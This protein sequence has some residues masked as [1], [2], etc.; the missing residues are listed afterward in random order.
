L[1]DSWDEYLGTSAA[2]KATEIRAAVQAHSILE[3]DD[4]WRRTLSE[5]ADIQCGRQL[6]HLFAVVL[7]FGM[8]DEPENVKTKLSTTFVVARHRLDNVYSAKSILNSTQLNRELRT[9]VSDTSKSA[10]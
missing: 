2:N 6:R 3:H 7:V 10:S 4:H 9:Q 1:K 8:P 5:A